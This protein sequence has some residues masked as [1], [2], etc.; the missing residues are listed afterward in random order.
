[1]GSRAASIDLPEP[2]GPIS[3]RLWPSAAAT[4][5]ARLALSWP[6][7]SRRSQLVSGFADFRLRPGQNLDAAEMIGELDQ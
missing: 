1:V 4:S 7:M 6:L 3:R 2:A 5:S